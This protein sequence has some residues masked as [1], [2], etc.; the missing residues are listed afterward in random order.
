MSSSGAAGE[1]S[2][3]L[4][5]AMVISPH[6][7]VL[8]QRD[9]MTRSC[10]PA[11]DSAALAGCDPSQVHLNVVD[12]G[13]KKGISENG[14]FFKAGDPRAKPSKNERVNKVGTGPEFDQSW[15]ETGGFVFRIR[16]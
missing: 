4:A 13:K 14:R 8:H 16:L 6:R 3:G 15:I 2:A 7:T 1:A 10:P 11:A 12:T 5:E 9:L